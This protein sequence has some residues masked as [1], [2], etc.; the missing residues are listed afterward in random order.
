[1]SGILE[2]THGSGPRRFL[3]PAHTIEILL[4]R[5]GPIGF[6]FRVHASRSN[7]TDRIG[8]VIWAKSSSQDDGRPHQFHNAAAYSPIMSD[9]E[10]PNLTVGLPVAIQEQKVGDSLVPLCDLNARLPHDRN[11]SHQEHTRQLA[12]EARNI[13]R[14]KQFGRRAE[15]DYR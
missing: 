9:P 13:T 12:L 15:M 10:R 11:A 1:M 14:P 2:K 7:C 6:R 8:D 5:A 3:E 4:M